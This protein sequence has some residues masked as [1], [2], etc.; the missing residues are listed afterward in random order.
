MKMQKV[1]FVLIGMM[2]LFAGRASAQQVKTDY[3][4]SANFGQY[5]T[6]SWERVKTQD[7]LFVDRIKNS[8]NA[9]LAAKGWTQVD[10]G[11]DISIIAIEMTTI[12]RLSIP[13]TTGLEEVG[14]GEVL[15]AVALA[16]QRQ[17]QIHTR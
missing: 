1:M 9:A 10:S 8:V 13:S 11:G 15:E 2:Y 17:Q 3:D 12:S 14:V 5:H 6:Y 4:R 16:R 7:P